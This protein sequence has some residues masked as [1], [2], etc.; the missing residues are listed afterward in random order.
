MS[1]KLIKKYIQ[2]FIKNLDYPNEQGR[3]VVIDIL[4]RV[5]EALPI[6][7]LHN[8]FDLI[9]YTCILK[10]IAEEDRE[11]KSNLR[12]VGQ[13]LLRRIPQEKTP[14]YIQNFLSWLGD[15]KEGV[16]Q[17]GLEGFLHL[18]LQGARVEKHFKVV[19]DKLEAGLNQIVHRIEQYWQ[20]QRE[21]YK[22]EK[23]KS[24]IQSKFLK[25]LREENEEDINIPIEENESL[26]ETLLR[27]VEAFVDK[28]PG[29]LTKYINNENK[30]F[31]KTFLSLVTFPKERF[32]VDC[33]GVTQI[34]LE[35]IG[36]NMK[37]IFPDASTVMEN[38]GYKL[39]ALFKLSFATNDFEKGIAETVLKSY[40][41]IS[42]DERDAYTVLILHKFLKTLLK[43]MVSKK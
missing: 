41:L 20:S 34:L 22:R 30:E 13:N 37:S 38:I 6:E 16:V 7:L 2:L 15:S 28:Q 8:Y 1:E 4:A 26:G 29:V 33:L 31:M 9:L 10:S 3:G 24:R 35:K 42:E 12:R 27:V 40:C 25:K 36:G 21:E 43:M 17:A 19:L 5:V 14:E 23:E 39:V 32:V 18:I 11:L